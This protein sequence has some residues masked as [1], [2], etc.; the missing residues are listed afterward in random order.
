LYPVRIQEYSEFSAVNYHQWSICS[1]ACLLGQQLKVPVYQFVKDAL[2][3]RF[4]IDW[5]DAL[6]SI[7]R[8]HRS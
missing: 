2:V 1:A 5:Y 4:G 7:A 6:T 3:R 8:E